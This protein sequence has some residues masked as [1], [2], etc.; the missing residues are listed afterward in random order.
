MNPKLPK[1][2]RR[3]ILVE[4]DEEHR[5]AVSELLARAGYEVVLAADEAEAAAH[6]PADLLIFG[7]GAV[8]FSLP[9]REG[10]ERDEILSQ[11]GAV[12]QAGLLAKELA[13][14]LGQTLRRRLRRVSRQAD[15]LALR[16]GLDPLLEQT[17]A[18]LVAAL[19]LPDLEEDLRRKN[20]ALEHLTAELR[21]A[22]AELLRLAVTDAL[23]GL[24]NRRHFMEAL[25]REFQRAERYHHPLSLLLIDVDHFKRINDTHGHPVGDAVLVG[26]AQHLKSSIRSTDLA[27]RLGGEE[28]AVAYVETDLAQAKKAAETL[29]KTISQKIFSHHK[30]QVQIT[31]SGGLATS[32]DRRV[33]S[34]LDLIELADRALYEAKTGGR[35]R[36]I[37]AREL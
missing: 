26:L 4:R 31:M 35:D 19:F 6:G 15:R 11:E 29:R 16:L 23:T 24:N 36:I 14:G 28:F 22:N 21:R 13:L 37:T 18:R 9:E 32:S 33:S 2:T 5:L 34:H 3:A 30:T 20:Q 1:E 7:R 25:R 8:P 17:R 12:R 27:A 10:E